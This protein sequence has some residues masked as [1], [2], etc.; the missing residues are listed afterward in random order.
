[1]PILGH[2]NRETHMFYEEPMKLEGQRVRGEGD[3]KDTS[4]ARGRGM[5]AEEFMPTHAAAGRPEANGG[6]V[7]FLGPTQ[8]QPKPKQ[9]IYWVAL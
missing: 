5:N 2:T 9:Q 8:K 7:G 4:T 6:Q 1:M 3:Q